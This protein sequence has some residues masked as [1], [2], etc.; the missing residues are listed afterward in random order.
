MT[1]LQRLMMGTFLCALAIG[2]AGC[3]GSAGLGGLKAASNAADTG[4]TALDATDLAA[5]ESALIASRILA[6]EAAPTV[7][8]SVLGATVDEPAPTGTTDEFS[9]ASPTDLPP[10]EMRG[11]RFHGGRQG[12]E[13][14]V[15]GG[16]GTCEMRMEDLGSGAARLHI[17]SE[18]CHLE[19]ME[20]G[21]V[22]I[23]RADQTVLT[24]VPPAAAGSSGE[25]TVNGATWTFSW[26]EDSRLTLVNTANGRTWTISED[27]AGNLTL[28][29]PGH[30]PHR[31]RWQPD[32]SVSG[33]SEGD[34][35]CFRFHGGRLEQE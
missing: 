3:G 15:R 33:E 26:G 13:W 22:K 31:G 28:A 24:I 27:E 25:L 14:R 16:E 1:R 8:A 10:F 35:T 2:V 21:S 18:T 5:I 29:R 11:H 12:G 34:G 9:G 32:G 4:T 20:D 7:G 6:A 30:P 19:R 17:G 23:L